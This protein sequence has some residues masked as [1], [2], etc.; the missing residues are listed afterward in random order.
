M[1]NLVK[2]TL[3]SFLASRGASSSFAALVFLG[4]FPVFSMQATGQTTLRLAVTPTSATLRASQTQQFKA[5]VTGTTNTA[6]TWSLNPVLGTITSTGL[7]TAPASITSSQTVTVIASSA[8]DSSK[9]ETATVSL[10]PSVSV[11][12]SPT[13]A[14]LR[15]SQTQQFKATVTGT[16]NTAVT[17]SLNPVLGTITSTGLYT[18]PASITSSQTVTVIASSAADS[19]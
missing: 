13:G 7:Y 11:V 12:V 1:A 3:R 14:A 6:V 16:T 19:S 18:A 17:W 8:A 9:T 4:F 2:S 10:Q 15:A 5:T